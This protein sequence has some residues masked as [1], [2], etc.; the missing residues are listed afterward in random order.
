MEHASEKPATPPAAN[1]HM[2]DEADIGSGELTAGQRETEEIIRQIPALPEDDGMDDTEDA[3]DA[4]LEG[5]TEIANLEQERS[6]EKDE[7]SAQLDDLDPVPP[8]G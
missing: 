8:R 5:E 7:P 3:D 4:A 1:K 2:W 6:L